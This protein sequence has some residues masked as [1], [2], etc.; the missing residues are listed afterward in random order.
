VNE[1][2]CH[3]EFDGSNL[4]PNPAA[5]D[6]LKKV[7]KRFAAKTDKNSTKHK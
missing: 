2:A 5:T 7:E 1:P 6:I 3:G 4:C